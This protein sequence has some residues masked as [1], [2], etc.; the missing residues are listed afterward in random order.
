MKRL[1]RLELLCKALTELVLSKGLA[2]REE[3]SV[4]TQQLDL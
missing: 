4:V 2:T 1:D 3:L